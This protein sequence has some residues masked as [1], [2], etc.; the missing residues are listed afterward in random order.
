MIG[1][2]RGGGWFSVSSFENRTE[3]AFSVQ[4]AVLAGGG[5]LRYSLSRIF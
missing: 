4:V 5:S 1:G 2:K 3:E